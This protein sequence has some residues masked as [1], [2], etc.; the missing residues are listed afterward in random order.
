MAPAGVDSVSRLGPFVRQQV[1]RIVGAWEE[2]AR[3]L[4]SLEGLSRAERIDHLPPLLEHIADM[5]D[6]FAA[7][8]RPDDPVHLA[9]K[10]ALQRLCAGF[11]L[12]ELLEEYA[13]LRSIILRLWSEESGLVEVADVRALA[14][15]IDSASTTS[16]RHYFA[17]RSRTHDALDAI[18]EVASSSPALESLFDR[19]LDVFA[20][21]LPRNDVLALLTRE[22]DL[23]LVRAARGLPDTAR[24]EM[25]FRVG[26][27]FVGE[28][29]ASETG[30]VLGE[31]GESLPANGPFGARELRALVGVPLRQ[32]YRVWTLEERGLYPHRERAYNAGRCSATQDAS[33]ESSWSRSRRGRG[34]CSSSRMGSG[35]SFCPWRWR[36]RC[37]WRSGAGGGGEGRAARRIGKRRGPRR[38]SSRRDGRRRSRRS[39]KPCP[40][41]SPSRTRHAASTH[42]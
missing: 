14:R 22:A 40:R 39:E 23:L 17:E 8:D 31:G 7:G 30:S 16:V 38:W 9:K 21:H 12:E 28:I 3:G 6:R 24:E 29:A 32:G 37:S 19:L 1:A 10:H 41:S 18:A 42:A 36:S 11:T 5:A 4:P 13:I 20:K 33:F 25:A 26:E 27:C 34:S 15:A 35:G 2:E